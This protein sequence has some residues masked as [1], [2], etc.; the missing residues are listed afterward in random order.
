MDN[1]LLVAVV[2]VCLAL[3]VVFIVWRNKLDRKDLENKLNQDYHKPHVHGN[4]VDEAE[5]KTV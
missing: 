2:L 4:D 5:D 1:Y 3:L